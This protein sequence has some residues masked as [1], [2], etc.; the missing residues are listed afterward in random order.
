M[1]LRSASAALA[2]TPGFIRPIAFAQWLPRPPY[3]F[4]S[5]TCG[6]QSCDFHGKR[7]LAGITPTMV[8]FRAFSSIDWPTAWGSPA[9]RLCHKP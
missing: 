5:I 7:K 9:K 6:I 4:G 3:S 2:E 1:I 8:R